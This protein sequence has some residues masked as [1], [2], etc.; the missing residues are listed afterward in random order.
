MSYNTGNSVEMVT[1]HDSVDC[2]ELVD[3]KSSQRK[4]VFTCLH[5]Q[6][7]YFVIFLSKNISF[8]TIISWFCIVT[9]LRLCGLRNSSA[10]LATLKNFDWHW[11]WHIFHSPTPRP[12][13]SQ[14]VC[15]RITPRCP[16]IDGVWV[17]GHVTVPEWIVWEVRARVHRNVSSTGILMWDH[18]HTHTHTFTLIAME[19]NTNY[20]YMYISSWRLRFRAV[21]NIKRLCY[22]AR[23]PTGLYILPS[24]ISFFLNDF[25]ENNYLRIHWT[26]FRNLFTEWKRFGCRWTIWTSFFR[27]LKRRCHG[28]QFCAESGGGTLGREGLLLGLGEAV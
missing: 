3:Y 9:L 5:P 2:Q 27:Y 26:D 16:D 24:V 6:N 17:A 25:S 18:T 10:I 22:L 8:S 12:N 7:M 21:R 19:T 28:N 11:H 14:N 4:R 15:K 20:I 23:L 1:F 13:S